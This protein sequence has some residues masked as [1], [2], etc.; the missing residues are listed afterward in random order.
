[1]NA[2]AIACAGHHSFINPRDTNGDQVVGPRDVLVVINALQVHGELAGNESQGDP[3]QCHANTLAVDVNGDGVL[4]PAD[5]LPVIN[6]LQQDHQQRQELAVARETW[7]RNGPS[8]YVMVHHWG[9]SAFIPA[10]TTTVRDGVI[11]SA[12]DDNG[13]E[14]PHGGSFNAGLTVEAVFDLIEQEF[15]QGPFR[16][17]VSYDP[18]TGR[19]TRVYSDPMEYAADDEWLFLVNSFSELS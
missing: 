11:V 13:I 10:V 19:P 7:S 4:S 17:E 6:W 15:D 2:G 8:D 5:V 12:V 16:I 14:K 3:P 9:Y 1:M 18:V